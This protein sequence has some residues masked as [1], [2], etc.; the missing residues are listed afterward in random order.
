MVVFRK[1]T[2]QDLEINEPLIK[3]KSVK[4][5]IKTP[6]TYARVG[7]LGYVTFKKCTRPHIRGPGNHRGK[8]S[9]RERCIVILTE[10]SLHISLTH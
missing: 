5:Y 8:A 1:A 3:M 9:A 4:R 7:K 2:F 10:A 6:H